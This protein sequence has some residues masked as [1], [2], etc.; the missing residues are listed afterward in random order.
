MFLIKSIDKIIIC[1]VVLPVF[2]WSCSSDKEE[3][4][5]ISTGIVTNPVTASG[6]AV[7]DNSLPVVAFNTTDRDFGIVIQ[8]E[9]VTH[10]FKYKNTGGTDLVISSA[11]AS[12]GCT[13][14]KWSKEPL[15]P[16]KEGEV[17]VIFDSSGRSGKQHKTI[18]LLTNAQPNKVV[19]TITCEV[20]IP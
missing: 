3:D 19:L 9:K 18:T 13:V 8:G 20:I 7:H 11:S 6:E 15:S 17:E 4:E 5:H 2:F 14:P 1:I 10:T 12:C 16:G